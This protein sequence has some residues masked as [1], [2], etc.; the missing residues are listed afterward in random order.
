MDSFDRSLKHLLARA[1][2]DLLGFGLGQKVHV[3]RPVST[4]LAGRGREVDGCYLI[5]EDGKRRIVHLEF[6]RRHQ[7]REHLAMDIAEAQIRLYR[8]ERLPITTLLWDLYGTPK[9]VRLTGHETVI[10]PD[11]PRL[12][13][14]YH[15]VNLRAMTYVELLAQGPPSLWPLVALT[16]D[17][18]HPEA[19]RQ[20]CQAIESRGLPPDDLADQWA[21]M[22][23]VAESERLRLGRTDRKDTGS[24]SLRRASEITCHANPVPLKQRVLVCGVLWF[25]SRG[26]GRGSGLGRRGG[27]GQ[28][29]RITWMV[30]DSGRGGAW[31]KGGV[32]GA[33]FRARRARR[34]VA[35]PGR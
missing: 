31:A 25:C 12:R 24:Q 8:R 26:A 20:T 22:W 32:L 15:R 3:V 2:D 4:T 27:R 29:G 7:N 10:G 13:C 33:G 35:I 5:E 30:E 11:G 19:L 14:R 1:P 6:H 9:Q 16:R 18:R 21:V 23:L 28:S 34:S 17:G